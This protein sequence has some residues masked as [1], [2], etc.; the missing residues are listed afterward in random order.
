MSLPGGDHGVRDQREV[1][2]IFHVVV[3]AVVAGIVGE[4]VVELCEDEV[5]LVV[6]GG[7][8]CRED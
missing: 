1:A 8:M 4:V 6:G 2:V 3:A 5:S 7:R